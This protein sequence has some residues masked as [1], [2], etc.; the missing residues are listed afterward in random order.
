MSDS[1]G[2]PI[3][4]KPFR[5]GKYGWYCATKVGE[6]WCNEKPKQFDQL[7]KD[8]PVVQRVVDAAKPDWDAI[9]A[10]KVRHGVVCAL[11]QAG[12]TKSEV[13]EEAPAYVDYVMKGEA[14]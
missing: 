9:A 12:K 5:E 13:F 7:P 8:S 14:F 11:I 2:C 4:N 10:G 3:H 6:G 1:P